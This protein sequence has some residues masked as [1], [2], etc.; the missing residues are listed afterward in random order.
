VLEGHYFSEDWM[1]CERWRKIGGEV[2]ADISIDLTHTG[3][4]DFK[5]SLIASL[6]H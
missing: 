6:I 3:Q 1:F 4:E 5:G 2:F